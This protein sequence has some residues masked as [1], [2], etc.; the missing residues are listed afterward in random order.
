L[1][2]FRFREN[3]PLNT[4][5]YTGFLLSYS[6]QVISHIDHLQNLMGAFV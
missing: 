4:I 6:Q 2:Q 5:E 1:P 3:L